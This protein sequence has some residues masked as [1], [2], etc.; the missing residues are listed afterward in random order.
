MQINFAH[1]YRSLRPK[2][3]NCDGVRCQRM[4]WRQLAWSRGRSRVSAASHVEG[5]GMPRD[6]LNHEHRRRRICAI[7]LGKGSQKITQTVLKRIRA[8][9]E[10][11]FFNPEDIKLPG[12]ICGSCRV[13]LSKNGTDDK[14]AIKKTSQSC[15]E[16]STSSLPVHHALADG[17]RRRRRPS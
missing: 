14:K 8:I 6:V 16:P 2:Y 13:M 1:Q 5:G 3:G 4:Y 15:C 17:A 11:R 7:C 9:P 12:G 10:R